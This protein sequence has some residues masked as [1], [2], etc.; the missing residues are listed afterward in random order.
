M[1]KYRRLMAAVR[2]LDDYRR[3]DSRFAVRA[4]D[5]PRH[6]AEHASANAKVLV[7]YRLLNPDDAA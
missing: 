7:E 6:W 4:Y 2:H 5:N 1:G 3:C